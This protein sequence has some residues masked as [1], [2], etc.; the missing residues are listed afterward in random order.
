MRR[1]GSAISPGESNCR[2]DLVKK[3][4]K[5]MMILSVDNGYCNRTIGQCLSGM[6]TTEPGSYNHHSGHTRTGISRQSIPVQTTLLWSHLRQEPEAPQIPRPPGT[7]HSRLREF[8]SASKRFSVPAAAGDAQSR[9]FTLHAAP[10]FRS[11][12]NIRVW[13]APQLWLMSGFL[14]RFSPVMWADIAR[15]Q[16]EHRLR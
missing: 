2:R 1:I 8:A 15:F 10:W 14:D 16:Q 13:S 3:R 11:P 12:G 9:D 6:E 4:L 5:R 7:A